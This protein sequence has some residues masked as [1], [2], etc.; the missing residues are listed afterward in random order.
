MT[1]FIYTDHAEKR[2]RERDIPKKLIEDI[3]HNPDEV[4]PAEGDSER[5]FRNIDDFIIVVTFEVLKRK[6]ETIKII[7][8]HKK[9]I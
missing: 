5:A 8:V 9:K 6:D 4:L 3:Y 7:S 2:I 1:K